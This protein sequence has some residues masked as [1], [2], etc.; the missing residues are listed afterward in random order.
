M[1]ITVLWGLSCQTSSDTL[2]KC[3]KLEECS[4]WN[5]F[6]GRLFISKPEFK[7]LDDA[8]EACADSERPSLEEHTICC[9]LKDI[10]R[11]KVDLEPKCLSGASKATRSD[12]TSFGVL[13]YISNQGQILMT[14]CVGSLITANHVLTSA[15]CVHKVASESIVA[16]VNAKYEYSDVNNTVNEDVE[17]SYVEYVSIHDMYKPGQLGFDIAL[18]RL[19]ERINLDSPDSPYPIC[20][21]TAKEHYESNTN[22]LHSFGWGANAEGDFSKTKLSVMLQRISLHECAF[23]GGRL[24][25]KS[26]ELSGSNKTNPI[27]TIGISGHNLFEGYSGAPLMYRK[28]GA[29]FLSGVVGKPL[30]P[31][32]SRK[33]SKPHRVLS[34]SVQRHVEWIKNV[35]EVVATEDSKGMPIE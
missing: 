11:K 15:H 35:L 19:K 29:W 20:I 5:Q 4:K 27:C 3:V 7:L 24:N 1:L 30:N 13:L 25:V 18:L 9:A 32:D 26:E 21:P 34:T 22:I 8:L 14:R 12:K 23:Y 31:E 16:L 10:Y 2:G 17:P 33:T 28:D 6:F